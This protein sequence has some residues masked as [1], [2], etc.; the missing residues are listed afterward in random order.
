MAN[1]Q[2]MCHLKTWQ[3]QPNP[4]QWKEKCTVELFCK[5]TLENITHVHKNIGC[6]ISKYLLYLNNTIV[7][8]PFILCL[9]IYTHNIMLEYLCNIWRIFSKYVNWLISNQHWNIWDTN[10][11]LSSNT[12][13]LWILL[14]QNIFSVIS[15]VLTQ[16]ANPRNFIFSL[17]EFFILF[18]SNHNR[19]NIFL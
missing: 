3:M 7:L 12:H 5:L 4:I 14:L 16:R 13:T 2:C 6:T 19:Q 18:N 11:R 8:I 1:R 9:Y 15:I 17:L 10:I